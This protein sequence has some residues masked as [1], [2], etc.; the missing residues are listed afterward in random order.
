MSAAMDR[1]RPGAAKPCVP[2]RASPL[3]PRPDSFPSTHRPT[4]FTD[5]AHVNPPAEAEST[6]P[7][8]AIAT[9]ADDF[10]WWTRPM[11]GVP[12]GRIRTDTSK[13][14]TPSPTP[15]PRDAAD[16]APRAL[17]GSRSRC[18]KRA[19]MALRISL[20]LLCAHIDWSARASTHLR[21]SSRS[22]RSSGLTTRM[23]RYDS[24][25]ERE[26]LPVPGLTHRYREGA[27]LPQDLVDRRLRHPQLRRGGGHPMPVERI[28][29]VLKT[30]ARWDQ[31]SGLHRQP[32]HRDTD[33]HLRG[34]SYNL[35]RR[36]SPAHR[37]APFP[38]TPYLLILEMLPK[39]YA[40][41][42]RNPQRS[43][44]DGCADPRRRSWAAACTRTWS[45]DMDL[46]PP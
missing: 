39:D 19:L 42:R 23:L 10:L 3:S 41:S 30:S 33:Y 13:T 25:N 8:P 4:M 32:A 37:R 46:Q 17:R 28:E 1:H 2:L 45:S 34:D 6:A 44:V 7:P 16:L 36:A 15:T 43:R 14:A 11:P 5:T 18:E 29:A 26:D 21:T 20:Y 24:L 38:E 40:C 22:A 35:K 9:F 27:L 31:A 12:P